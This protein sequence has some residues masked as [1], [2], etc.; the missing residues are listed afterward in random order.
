MSN[1]NSNIALKKFG[2]PKN[3]SDICLFQASK[4]SDFVTGSV[5]VADGGQIKKLGV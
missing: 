5:W 1:I 2:N 4:K 3:I